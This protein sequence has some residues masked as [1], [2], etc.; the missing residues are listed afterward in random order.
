[1]SP[2]ALDELD[3]S[4]LRLIQEEPKM[5]L[6]E[7]EKRLKVSKSTIHY[8]L[9]KLEKLGVIK[10]Y[11]AILDA[12]KLGFEFNIAILVRAAYG[13]QYHYEVGHFLAANPNI[14]IVYYVLGDID[15]IV[16]GKFPSRES[17]LSFLETLI[18]SNK[19][20]RTST[21]VVIKILKE[22]LKLNI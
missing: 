1:V 21:M 16:V 7:L 22:D 11:R 2:H 19:I 14:Q 18:N 10:G 15:F 6:H 8:R 9:K 13:P 5:K 20:E 4:I 12:E 17:Y 3:L